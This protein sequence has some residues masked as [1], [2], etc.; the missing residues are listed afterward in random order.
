MLSVPA[1]MSLWR[2]HDECYGHFRRYGKVELI[3]KVRA[4]GLEV[5]RCHFFRCAFFLPL[6]VLAQLERRRRITPRDNLYALPAWVN[7]VMETQILWE[8]RS[9]LARRLP[10]GVSLLCVG[11]RS[12]AR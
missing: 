10:F 5:V 4:A 8:Y 7:R 2:Y 3:E 1:F 9:G 11:R 6:W 12:G